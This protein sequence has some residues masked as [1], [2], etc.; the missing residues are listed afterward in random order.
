VYSQ[1]YK[2]TAEVISSCILI[3]TFLGLREDGCFPVACKVPC[4]TVN[5][6]GCGRKR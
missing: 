5:R 4:R 1:P 6:K 2:T 3:R